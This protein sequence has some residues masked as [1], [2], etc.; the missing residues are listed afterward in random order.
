[1]TDLFSQ[2][3]AIKILWWANNDHCIV[4]HA[5]TISNEE[6]ETKQNSSNAPRQNTSNVRRTTQWLL[7]QPLT[8]RIVRMHYLQFSTKHN[9]KTVVVT[10]DVAAL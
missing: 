6:N 10:L 8:Q 5:A 4:Y 1:V 3:L 7:L 9:G 2:I